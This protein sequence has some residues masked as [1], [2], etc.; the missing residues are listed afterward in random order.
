MASIQLKNVVKKYGKG[1]AELAEYGRYIAFYKRVRPVIQQG[2]LYR[3]ERLEQFGRSIWQYVT[4]DG[5]ESVYALATRDTMVGLRPLP[6]PLRG[7]QAD[8]LYRVTDLDG[9]EVLRAT[10]LDLMVQGLPGDDQLELCHRRG[11]ARMVHLQR[12]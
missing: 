12:V 2:D 6:P 9:Q 1:K 11:F 7:L 8:A 10:G 3:L 5:G 4:P